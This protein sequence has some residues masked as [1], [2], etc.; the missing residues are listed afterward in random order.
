MSR[1][2]FLLAEDE[3]LKAHLSTLTV[4]DDHNQ[5]RQ[6]KVFFRYPEGETEKHYPFITIEMV[7]LNQAMNRQQSE[8][9]VYYS[10]QNATNPMSVDHPSYMGYSPSELDENGMDSFVSDDIN[11]FASMNV[12]VPVDLMYQIST[13][14]RSALHDRQ[15][16]AKM[17][18]YTF[19]FRSNYLVVPSDGT[20]RRL[21][22]LG[23]S[24]SDLLD[25]E[26]GYRKRIF[27]KVYSLM[28]NAEI[29]RE[30]LKL[31]KQATSIVGTITGIKDDVTVNT[32]YLS[33]EF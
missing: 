23:W 26:T 12:P 13:F 10:S 20:I 17:L 2:G 14:T 31:V 16:T 21:D 15:L 24:Q 7:G 8:H 25:G 22:L 33:E 19:P 30:D 32:P 4:S 1:A 11:D 27:R 5:N 6:V 18:R 28:I 29:P 9:N 3:A